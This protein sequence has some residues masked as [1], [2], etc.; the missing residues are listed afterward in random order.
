MSTQDTFVVGYIAGPRGHDAIALASFLA[1]SA[2]SRLVIVQVVPEPSAFAATHDVRAG[3]DPIVLEQL[4]AWAEEAL[5]LVDAGVEAVTEVR[6]ASN[7]AQG[8]LD[9]A[10][11][12]G[13]SLIVIGAQTN[14]FRRQF[15]IGTVASTLL[16]AAPVPVAL[17]PGGFR[18]A[19]EVSRVTAVYGT[20]PGAG[21]L[22]GRAV[23]RS[24]QRDVPLRLLSLVQV[25]R[26]PPSQVE[27][28]AAQVGAYG[29]E[30]L[31][32]VSEGLLDSG[33]ASV[34]VVEGASFEDAL[35][36]VDWQ[37]GDYAMLGSS[38]LAQRGRIFLGNTAQRILRLLPV[39][40]IVVPAG[41]EPID[42]L[43]PAAD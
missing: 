23:E 28:L 27:E 36:R 13:A 26:T 16:H 39:P 3:I 37:P 9:A 22:I 25:D 18:S 42:D 7:E 20:R 10:A 30:R 41:L 34:E 4:D 29:G 6:V 40:V 21:E 43:Q 5:A 35:A 38:R 15:T 8:L 11:E 14:A 33:Q 12:H 32:E 19:D 24:V 17:A 1:R 31:A 2:G